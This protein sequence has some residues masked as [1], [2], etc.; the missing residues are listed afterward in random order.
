MCFAFFCA[1]LLP[2]RATP[3]RGA[4]SNLLSLVGDLSVSERYS[5]SNLFL[6]K[7]LFS[8]RA[9]IKTQK[10]HT[11]ALARSTQDDELFFSFQLT[12]RNKKSCPPFLWRMCVWMVGSV[13]EDDVSGLKSPP[14]SVRASSSSCH[15][16]SGLFLCSRSF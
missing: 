11:R 10:P 3:S 6:S 15:R 4:H 8:N 9:K 14:E 13:E 2:T 7:F 5:M 12:E 1:I 16:H